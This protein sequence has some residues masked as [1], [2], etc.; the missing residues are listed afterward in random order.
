V[1]TVI[2]AIA[3]LGAGTLGMLGLG[4]V[5]L[6]IVTLAAVTF[7]LATR[8][9]RA[10]SLAVATVGLLVV[11]LGLL[12]LTPLLGVGM[13]APHV[14][15]LVLV[16]LGS[17][18]SARLGTQPGLRAALG[19]W[20]LA[21]ASSV[22][23]GVFLLT[24]AASQ[25]V[26]GALRLA[27]A[28]N[29]DAV[30]V[31]V[32]SRLMVAAGG[33]DQAAVPQPTPLP[34]AMA[35]ASMEGGRST[36]AA[37]QLLEHDVART[38]QVWV[39]LI[40]IA[41]LLVGAIVG[42]ALRG[43]SR[44][45]ALT[46]T[47]AASALPLLWFVVGVQFE[48]GFVNSAFAIALLLCAWLFHVGAAEHPL[49][50]FVGLWLVLLALL[51][52]W[53]PLIVCVIGLGI[54]LVVQRRRDLLASG[55]LRLALAA[56]APLAFVAYALVV[57][58]PLFLEQS[59]AL[60]SDGGFPDI[61]SSQSIIIGAVVALVALLAWQRGDRHSALG[62]LAVLAGLA[63]GLTYLLLQ[64]VGEEFYWGY[65]PAKFAWTTWSML[66]PVAAGIAAGF[67]A[68]LRGRGRAVLS[69]ASGAVV[70]ALLF[71]PGT[72]AAQVPLPQ[73][74]A[75]TAFDNKNAAAEVTFALSGAEEGYNVLWRTKI[76]DRWP[77]HW[78]LQLDVPNPRDNPLGT[79]ATVPD[80]S[81][82][83]VCEIVGLLGP[84]A[85]VWT[86]DPA[87]VDDLAAACPDGEY[88]V[89]VADL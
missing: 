24:M 87:T 85:V 58:V 21:L 36:L 23:A 41:C 53:S 14:V 44:G 47:A 22:G 88:R 45:W 66:V 86:A 78:L 37:S 2:L 29:G 49:V 9:P 25:V 74:V 50:A 34:F 31:M 69:V 43:A 82:E 65:Y 84:S 10:L 64:R 55:P 16:S 20:R 57:T 89:E 12:T 40:A 8:L 75:G 83:Q 42:S 7:A 46:V 5:P 48:F 73:L 68:D 4:L 63:L 6:W 67:L 72:P 79:Y 62:V 39:L 1:I 33:I 28:M 52:V 18:W 11:E 54:I 32:F 59:E 3:A 80:L 35:A 51:A 81:A 17:A 30:H 27:W 71:G 61:P 70:V 38:A 26:P 15:L 19:D 76:G 77:N 56:L 60:G 13:T